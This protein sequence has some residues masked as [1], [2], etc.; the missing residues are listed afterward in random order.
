MFGICEIFR[1]V[2]LRQTI[3]VTHPVVMADV[4]TDGDSVDPNEFR[5]RKSIAPVDKQQCSITGDV[6]VN[7][8]CSGRVV[9]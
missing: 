8:R 2:T 6:N 3:T 1:S 5:D 7:L 9:F 4:D